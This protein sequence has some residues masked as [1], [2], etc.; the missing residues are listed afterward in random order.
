MF[1][2]EWLIA[3]PKFKIITYTHLSLLWLLGVV[4]IYQVIS[5]PENLTYLALFDSW[6]QIGA[7]VTLFMAVLASADAFSEEFGK[8]TLSFIMSRPLSRNYLYSRKIINAILLVTLPIAIIGISLILLDLIFFSKGSLFIIDLMGL[9]FLLSLAITIVC[10]G[11]LVSLFTSNSLVSLILT[12][13]IAGI[14]LI[15]GTQSGWQLTS[16]IVFLTLNGASHNLEI[17][18]I[19][20]GL[21]LALYFGGL[22]VFSRR[23]F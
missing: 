21:N 22:I 9:L 23:Q 1:Y 7:F 20:W 3:R 12:L 11:M 10:L 16:I 17:F 18:P 15:I 5:R 13:G 19:L 6:Y 4:L 14:A 8:N 2:K